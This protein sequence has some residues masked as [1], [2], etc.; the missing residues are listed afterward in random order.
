MKLS[1]NLANISHWLSKK[2]FLNLKKKRNVYFMVPD[3]DWRYQELRTFQ[4]LWTRLLFSS[5]QFSSIWVLC[6]PTI[7]HLTN[8]IIDHEASKVSQKLGILS[9][10]RLLF[11]TESANRLYKSMVLPLL[12]HGDITWHGFGLENQ[13]RIE[14]LQRKASRIVLKKT[15][16]PRLPNKKGRR[17]AWSQVN[18]RCH[19]RKTQMVAAL[20]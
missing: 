15:F 20:R 10:V 17:T 18:K 12:G 6:S 3:N 8:I 13:Q 11:T 16:S 19:H 5:P 2:R 4:W 9:R 7:C 14:R 1:L